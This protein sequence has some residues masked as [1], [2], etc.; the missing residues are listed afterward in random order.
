MP[1]AFLPGPG[2]CDSPLTKANCWSCTERGNSL[3]PTYPR[4]KRV[5]SAGVDTMPPAAQSEDMLAISL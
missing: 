2:G 4:M 1:A 3:R 5:R